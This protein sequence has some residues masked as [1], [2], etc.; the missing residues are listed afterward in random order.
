MY[1]V[2]RNEHRRRKPDT[3]SY[4]ITGL[5][6]IKHF[7]DTEKVPLVLGLINHDDIKILCRKVPE[8]I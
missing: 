1:Q 7:C 3:I 8:F 4:F 5:L 6:R 2:I